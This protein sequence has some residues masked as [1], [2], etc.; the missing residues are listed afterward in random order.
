MRVNDQP[1]VKIALRIAGDDVAP[2]DAVTTSVVPEVRM[3][4]LYGK[5]L[6]VIVDRES[7]EWEIDWAHARAAAPT[8]GGLSATDG[9][10]ADRLTRL[11]DLLR[12]DLISREEYDATRAR[13]LDEI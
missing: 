7:G 8:F 13:I 4:L 3:P 12:R 11:D 6:P 2:F 9:A 5:E 10:P 1:M